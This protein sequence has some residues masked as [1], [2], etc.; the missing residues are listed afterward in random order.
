MDYKQILMEDVVR[1]QVSMSECKGY[2]GFDSF[3][4]HIYSNIGLSSWI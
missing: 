3:Y 4:K 2:G 1:W